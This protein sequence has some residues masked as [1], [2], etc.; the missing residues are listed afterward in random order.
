M[1]VNQE[2]LRDAPDY[3]SRAASASASKNAP[4]VA[5]SE[6][7]PIVAEIN[8]RS[9]RDPLTQLPNTDALE[10]EPTVFG[11]SRSVLV[12]AVDELSQVNGKL[13]RVGGDELLIEVAR[14]LTRLSGD[15]DVV[16]RLDGAEFAILLD[17]A[18]GRRIGARV[19]RVTSALQPPIMV[20]HSA[21]TVRFRIGT[22]SISAS[23]RSVA[24]LLH[25]ADPPLV[26]IG[27]PA[28]EAEHSSHWS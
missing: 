18:D 17:D 2:L 4:I 23:S 22:A 20:G 8:E 25:A 14:R 19:R 10:C 6:N 12:I 5:A 3:S 21:V 13:G 7:S 11:L 24:S 9:F 28:S 26:P 16:A 27:P 15:G 1:H